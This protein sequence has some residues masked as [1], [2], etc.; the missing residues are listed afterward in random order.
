MAAPPEQTL[1]ALLAARAADISRLRYDVA[2]TELP[3]QWDDVWLLRYV[4]SFPGTENAVK[5]VEL[6]RQ[7]VAW[8]AENAG[9]LADAAAG[10]PAPH[11]AAIEPFMVSGFHQPSLL[12][13]PLFIVRAGL[14]NPGAV[15]DN[16]PAEGLLSWLM[17]S[18]EQAFLMCDAETRKRRT[19]VKA[20]NIVDMAHTQL[21]M[22]DRRFFAVLGQS[23]KLSEAM[24][25]Q[26]LARAVNIH[27]PAFFYAMFSIFKVFMTKKALEKSG[28][29]PGASAARP[30]AASCPFASRR[31][32]VASLPSFLGGS[33]KCLARGGCVACVPN[34]QTRPALAGGAHASVTVPARGV[35]DVLVAAREPGQRLVW[36]FTIA[37]KG[38][39]VSAWLTTGSDVVVPLLARRKHMAAEGLVSG[40]VLVPAAGTVT[41]RFCNTHSMFTG[42]KVTIYTRMEPPAAVAAPATSCASGAADAASAAPTAPLPPA[43]AEG[44]AM[45]SL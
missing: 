41:M 31:F 35:H 17:Y 27:P 44:V 2:P 10:R 39:E 45:I 37:D 1:D 25:P 26:A 42:K 22:M 30:T 8:R 13:E 4:L 9:M 16:V 24:Y 15:L 28:V 6:V 34:A 32:D 21:A 29:C 12:G 23:S 18:K 19:I 40:E 33:C 11:A 36:G 38:L 7:C 14:S 5:R 3:P 20:I 43:V